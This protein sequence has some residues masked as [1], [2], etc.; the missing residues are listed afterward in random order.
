MTR[1]YPHSHQAPFK[2]LTPYTEEDADF[3]FGREPE[4]EIITANLMA[5]R[6]TLLYGESGVGKSSVLR[7][8]VAY[9]LRRL[10]RQ[11]LMEEGTPEFNVVVF[12]SWRDD[13]LTGLIN[14]VR[15]SV[16]SILKDRQSEAG[17]SSGSL[18]QILQT[19]AEIVGGELFIILDQFEEYFLYNPL[20]DGEGTFAA[21]FPRAVNRP[22]LPANFIISIRE[23]S[24]AKLDRFKGRIHNLLDNRLRI[25]HLD[26]DSAMSAIQNPIEEYNRRQGPGGTHFDIEPSLVEAVLD[27]VRTGRVVL[28]GPGRGQIAVNMKQMPGKER[29]ETPYLQLVLTRLW[30]KELQEKSNI[31]RLETLIRMGGAERIVRTHLDATMKT[32]N[33]D[34]KNVAAHIFHYLVTPSGTKITHSVSDLVKYAGLAEEKVRPVVDKL[35]ESAVRILRPVEPS[36][37]TPTISRYEI[38]HDVLAHAVMDW[39]ARYTRELERAEAERKAEA[40]Q[41]QIEEQKRR[42]EKEAGTARRLRWLVFALIAVILLA[43][44]AAFVAWTQQQLAFRQS[45]IAISREL[46]AEAMNNLETDP[47]LSVLLAL[48]AVSATYSKDKMVTRQAENALHEAVQASQVRL[49]LLGHADSVSDAAFSPDGKRLATASYDKTVKIWDAVS[50]KALLTL[51]GQTDKV[52]S[53]AF[54]P[55]GKHLATACWDGTVKV[56][57]TASGKLLF[58]VSKHNGVVW[59][60][61]FSPDGK[62]IVTASWDKTAKVWDA[63]SG[64]EL[65]TLSDHTTPVYGAAFSPDGK[66]LVTAGGD[67]KAKIW[68]VASG[69]ELLT[70]SGHRTVVNGAAFSPDGKQLVT[71]SWDNTAKLWDATSGMEL[72][73]LTGH[74]DRV[75][76]AAFSP[77]G[78]RLVTVGWDKTARVWDTSFGKELFSLSGH[79]DRILGVAYSPDGKHLVTASW[80]K[81]ARVWDA[82]FGKELFTLSGHDSDVLGVNFSPDGKYLATASADKTAKIWDADSGDEL[83]TLTG[84]MDKV[85]GASFSPDGKRLVTAS[86]DKTA[87]VWDIE[88]GKVVFTLSG[89]GLEVFDA[90]FSPN[91]KRLATAGLGKTAKIWDA[92]TGSELFTLSK[93]TGGVVGLDFS[94]NGDRLATSSLDGTAR[95]WETASGK[96]LLTLAGHNGEVIDVAFSSDAKSLAT[97]GADKKV[98]IWD[99]VTGEELLTLTGHM[100]EVIGVAFAP[101]GKSLA[102][103]SADKTAKIWDAASG[104]ELLTLTGHVDW[105]FGVAFSPDGKRLATAGRDRVVNVYDLDI[106]D[107]L[108]LAR[109]RATRTLTKAECRKYLHMNECPQILKEFDKTREN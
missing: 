34:E 52:L 44:G 91:G 84:H 15:D 16:S 81:S 40:Q 90:I 4:L 33:E 104:D 38:F 35:T 68:D 92:D 108:Y 57:E 21:E 64:Q 6:L 89:H 93:H 50:G 43:A 70:L 86:F 73:T 98:K 80:D 42:A 10:A 47:E 103:V 36:Q 3:F 49:T 53:V 88:S 79:T 99:S 27:Q 29:I 22:G 96:L 58:N 26:R 62:F 25:E 106:E 45:K 1:R 76:A 18:S 46:A 63:V 74:T 94:P 30:D 95:V 8:G 12:S 78:K 75:L 65:L 13:P 20:E 100:D 77:D 41:R 19:S 9:Q 31:L 82:D 66:H 14:R 23:D 28:E 61:A 51:S 48:Q 59:E 102:T 55:D 109:S 54:S 2:G 32:L 60:V 105:V 7:A 39:R 97:A 69:K 5:S 83:L 56:W 24:L 37:Y 71:V 107:F 85:V 67:G 11:N 17:K 72:F 87:K 101:D